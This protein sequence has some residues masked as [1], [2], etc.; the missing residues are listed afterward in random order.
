MLP[1]IGGSC[2]CYGLQMATIPDGWTDDMSVPLPPGVRVEDVVEL[3]LSSAS[4]GTPGEQIVSGLL[5]L[6][7]SDED[8]A[9][10]CDRTF[11][12]V[13]RAA[14]HNPANQP[15]EVKDPLAFASYR[16]C[17]EDPSIMS[18]VRPD[19]AARWQSATARVERRWWQFWK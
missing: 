12:G 18:A 17:V 14:T 3:I 7:L 1:P 15:S 9:L 4:Q 5:A 6:G 16:R 11:G 19:L 2:T 8:A 13:V 10:A